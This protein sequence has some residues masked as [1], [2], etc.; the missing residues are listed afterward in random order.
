MRYQPAA[1]D[2]AAQTEYNKFHP[3]HGADQRD[4][5]KLDGAP[6]LHIFDTMRRTKQPITYRTCAKTFH[7]PE[8]IQH[9]LTRT[10]CS[11]NDHSWIGLVAAHC[12]LAT[13]SA[14]ALTF[15]ELEKFYQEI[16]QEDTAVAARQDACSLELPEHESRDCI[17]A[18]TRLAVVVPF[19]PNQIDKVESY[20]HTGVTAG[21]RIALP[22]HRVPCRW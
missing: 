5:N 10:H 14:T 22:S 16:N 20:L 13:G 19:I 12:V 3:S 9:K 11:D 17:K 1:Q 7:L 2:I 6:R 18:V 15:A 8:Y 21:H 4:V